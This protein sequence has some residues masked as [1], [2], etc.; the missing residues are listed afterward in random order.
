MNSTVID[1]DCC[2]V[3]GG[4]AGVILAFLLARQGVSVVLLE[5]HKNF[6]RDWRGDAIHPLTM[7]LMETLGLVDRLLEIPH[8]NISHLTMGSRVWAEFSKLHTRYPYVTI[9]PQV[10][11]LELVV[12]EAKQYPHFQM[13]MS[14]NAQELIQEGEAVCGVRY[15]KDGVYHE[16]RATLTVGADGRASRLRELADLNTNVLTSAPPMDL[17]SFRLPKQQGDPAA[18]ARF[19]EGYMIIWFEQA[20]HWLFRYIF[21]KG[22]YQN[23]R[24]AGLDAL[25]QSIVALIPEFS[26]RLN[27]LSDWSD[28]SFLCVQSNRLHQWYRNGLLLIG[29]AAHT[30]SPVGGVGI[31]YAIQDAVAAANVLAEPLKTG[32]LQVSHLQAVQQQRAF[33]TRVIQIYQSIIQEGITSRFDRQSAIPVRFLLCFWFPLSLPLLGQQYARFI[34]YLIGFGIDPARPNDRRSPSSIP[35]NHPA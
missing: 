32:Q 7:E 33:P 4:P 9:I 2:I 11:F 22:S 21:S 10:N 15:H 1:T 35:A 28:L 13:L 18:D 16:I 17:V 14:T 12:S 24:K 27:S 25:K 20:D 8:H 3:G 31:N 26:N 30:M 29:D 23:I 6:D 5:V 19:G 34:A